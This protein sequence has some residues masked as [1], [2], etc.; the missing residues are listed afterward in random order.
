LRDEAITPELAQ[1]VAAAVAG[2]LARGRAS[3]AV[4]VSYRRRGAS[5][6]CPA[7]DALRPLIASHVEVADAW[8]VAGGRFR[9]PECP[10]RACCPDGGRAV[11]AAPHGMPAYGS[12]RVV[13]HGAGHHRVAAGAGD[14]RK[15]A[16]AAFK[17]A[18]RAR[19]TAQHGPRGATTD[20]AQGGPLPRGESERRTA[21]AN[22]RR[23][24]LDGWRAALSDAAQGTLPGDAETGKLAAGLC[25][26]VVR[27]AAVISMVPGRSDVADALC[28][29]PSAPGVREALSAM[30]AA[31]AAVR[32][33]A[34]D[35]VALVALAEHVASLCDEGA[36]PA[37]TLAGLALWWSGD[38]ST[39]DHAITCALAAQPGYRLA[40]LVECALQAHMPPGWIAAA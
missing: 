14:R 39:A 20:G 31:D 12:S 10:D 19:V 27:D 1:S 30:I 3:T 22:W 15:R 29:D 18:L 38:D 35:V 17:R 5:L 26:V 16:R 40:Q 13:G 6:E 34:A 36:A 7:L 2:H 8:V 28:G 37:L 21:L 24:R 23:E 9:A 33:R 4:L 25:D 32:P 11:P